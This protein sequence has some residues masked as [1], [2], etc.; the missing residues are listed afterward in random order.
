MESDLSNPFNR[1]VEAYEKNNISKN[2]HHPMVDARY[3]TTGAYCLFWVGSFKFYT[4]LSQA[5]FSL[6]SINFIFVLDW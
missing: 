4:S 2:K 5:K 6:L 1:F 3:M